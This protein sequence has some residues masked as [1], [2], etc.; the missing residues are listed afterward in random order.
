MRIRAVT[1]RL[2]RDVIDHFKAGG[3]GWQTR[4]DEALRDWIGKDGAA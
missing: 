1:I 3:R 4:I 2:S